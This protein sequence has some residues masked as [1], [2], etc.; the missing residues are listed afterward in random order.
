MDIKI[1]IGE[2]KLNMRA[3]AIIMHNEKNTSA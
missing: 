2:Y 1:D 3:A